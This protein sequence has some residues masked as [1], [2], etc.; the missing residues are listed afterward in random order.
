MLWAIAIALCAPPPPAD[1]PA[2]LEAGIACYRE[3][4]YACADERIAEAL[5]AGLNP[6]D[7]RRAWYHRALLA[8]A[9]RDRAAVV[10]AVRALYA[11]DPQ[12]RPEGP[13]PPLFRQVLDAE[14][15]APPPPPALLLRADAATTRLFGRDADRWS[16][17][18]GAE[19]SAA[20]LYRESV[21]FGVTAGWSDHN[22]LE[23]GVEDLDLLMLTAGAAFWRRLGPIRLSVG[24]EVGAVRVA[25]D[26]VLR[27]DVY[28]G[29][30]GQAPVDLAWPLYAG[31]GVGARA[32][33]GWLAVDQ[34]GESAGS[35][36]FPLTVGLRYSP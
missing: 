8:V 12:Y 34:D 23:F 32:A 28:W 35:L 16:E 27:D 25:R 31:L 2:I 18:L 30:F 9:W 22:P 26:G 7:T 15:P 20:F 19:A 1:P 11:L 4:D 21:S 6:T 5:A 33:V 29:A 17:G 13:T 3:L 24:A 36:V 14:R 10:R